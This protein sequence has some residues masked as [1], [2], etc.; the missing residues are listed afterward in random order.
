MNDSHIF[1]SHAVADKALVD[2]LVSDIIRLGCNVPAE[3]IFCSSLQGMGIPSGQSFP[4]FIREKI[5][6]PALVIAVL[7]PSYLAS[8]FCLCELGATWAM[9]HNFFAIIVSP[10][11]RSKMKGV[12]TGI[13]IEKIE[14][15]DG[16][17]NLRDRIKGSLGCEVATALWS[18][19]RDTF[20][21]NLPSVLSNLA[22]P[23]TVD[24]SELEAVKA[25]Y[26]AAV[27][28]AAAKDDEIQILNEL[29][30]KLRSCKDAAEVTAV[31]A[32]HTDENEQFDNL[33]DAAAKKLGQLP[34]PSQEALFQE[35]RKEPLYCIGSDL[36]VERYEADKDVER[37]YLSTSDPGIFYLRKDHPAV[38]EAQ[39]AVNALDDFLG[40]A[41]PAFL[42]ALKIKYSV[43][44][45]LSNR[46]FWNSLFR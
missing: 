43:P 1:L 35:Q 38:E 19:K 16:L 29:V 37:S 14:D 9:A 41:S 30:E 25:N 12:L 45:E 22:L 6:K 27:T 28:D 15:A 46:D 20:L 5:Q 4:D 8:E 13:Q 34:R 39:T 23:S 3:R 40:M 33:V 42:K 21:K 24:R 18:A 11:N 26:D 31:I 2:L 32:Q 36:I 44:I 17:D 10:A 7:T